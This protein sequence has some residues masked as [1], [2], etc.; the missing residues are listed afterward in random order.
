MESNFERKQISCM[1]TVLEQVQSG[2]QT[3][4]IRLPEGM[5]DVGQV[6]A[7]WGQPIAR[8]KEWRDESLHFSGGMMVW[9]LYLPEDGSE[10]RCLE[11]WIPFQMRW[12]L[13]ENTREG[14][15]RLRC[16]P[17]FVDG[18]STSPRKIL[19]RAGMSVLAE[20]F[21][22]YELSAA[23]PQGIPEDVALLENTYPLRMTREAGE[24]T[25]RMDEEMSLP[26]SVPAMEELVSWRM[27]PRITDRKVLGDKAVFRG[28]G[29]LHVLYR[30]PQ[31]QIHSWDFELPFSQYTDL[32]GE[33]GS[34]ARMD[35]ALLPTAMEL[36]LNDGRLSLKSGMSAQYRITDKQ[37]L[38]LAEDA[39]SPVRELGITVEDLTPPV[40]LE[41]RQENLYGEQTVQAQ[42]NMAADV[43]FLPDFPK[44]RRTENGVQLEY[45]G[46]F[47]VLYYGEDGRLHGSSA[48]WESSQTVPAGDNSRILAVPMGASAQAIAGNGQLQVKAEVPVEMTASA[49]Q[50]IPMITGLEL[51]QQKQPSPGRPSLILR[52][53]GENSLWDLAK[54]SGSTTEAIRRANG[55]TGEPVPDQ[56]LLIPVI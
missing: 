37:P 21:V 6:V 23:V 35:L 51:G 53:A 46:Q 33:Y 22:P 39:Y 55:L 56:M 1:K 49:D 10:E 44:Q 4:E 52:R 30:S 36:D 29:N 19:V 28:N 48:R 31:G 2:E 15:L 41:N 16:L 27:D 5:P 13:P 34:E 11:G 20:A 9:V 40:I 42:A 32:Q 14:I 18:R 38:T 17:R 8:S 7:A 47:Q 3:L 54:A 25:F 26:D 43:Q 12:E 24:K 50:S 45:P